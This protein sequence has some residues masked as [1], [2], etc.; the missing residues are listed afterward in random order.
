VTH[1]NHDEETTKVMRRPPECNPSHRDCMHEGDF[2]Q[3]RKRSDKQEER[4]NEVEKQVVEMRGDIRQIL[5][6]N[7]RQEQTLQAVVIQASARAE[8]NIADKMK[9]SL[10]FWAVPIVGSGVY[11]LAKMVELAQQAARNVP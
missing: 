6:S 8:F 1:D 11:W 9:E 7:V 10:I 5:S 3:Y 2:S 4:I